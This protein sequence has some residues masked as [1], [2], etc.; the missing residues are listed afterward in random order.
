MSILT[1]AL[2]GVFFFWAVVASAGFVYSLREWAMAVKGLQAKR[3]KIAK[4]CMVILSLHQTLRAA[5]RFEDHRDKPYIGKATLE[6]VEEL[7]DGDTNMEFRRVGTE[8][9]DDEYEIRVS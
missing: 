9:D 1:W 8:S 4:A 3:T 2:L 7:V 5:H 6:F